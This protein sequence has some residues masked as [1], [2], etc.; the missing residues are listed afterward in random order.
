[1]SKRTKAPFIK[2]PEEF[3]NEKIS[4][5][6]SQAVKLYNHLTFLDNKYTTEERDYFFRSNQDIADELDISLPTFK[7]IKKELLEK[8]PDLI[9][10]WQVNVPGSAK[11]I[12]AYRLIK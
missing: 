2:I 12:T 5:L 7:R 8:C 9:E 4:L 1:M 6:S 10:S 3:A 11:H